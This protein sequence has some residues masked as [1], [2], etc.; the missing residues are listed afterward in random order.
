M[1]WPETFFDIFFFL[2]YM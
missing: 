1:I 2:F